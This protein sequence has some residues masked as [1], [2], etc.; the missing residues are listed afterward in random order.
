MVEPS[1]NDH[2]LVPILVFR[3][4]NLFDPLNKASIR[5]SGTLHALSDGDDDVLSLWEKALTIDISAIRAEIEKIL[6]PKQK[7]SAC[8]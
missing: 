7:L 5:N 4:H 1:Y 8:L 3:D 6:L 2:V